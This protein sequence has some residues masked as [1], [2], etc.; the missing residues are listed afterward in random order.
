MGVQF[1]DAQ[2]ETEDREAGHPFGDRD[3]PDVLHIQ[4]R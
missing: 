1:V 4:V 2:V 3:K